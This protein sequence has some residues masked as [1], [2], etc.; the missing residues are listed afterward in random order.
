MNRCWRT[1]WPPPS[2]ATRTGRRR[3]AAFRRE[4]D[5]A[6][7]TIA[8]GE[9]LAKGLTELLKRDLLGYTRL[10]KAIQRRDQCLRRAQAA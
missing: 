8:E 9:L 4:L 10:V 7:A 5:E 2:W 6:R 1:G 3:V